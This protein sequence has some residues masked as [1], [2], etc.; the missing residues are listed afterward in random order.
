ME[1]GNAVRI[2]SYT[3]GRPVFAGSSEAGEGAMSRVLKKLERV[4]DQLVKKFGMFELF[5]IVQWEGDVSWDVLVVAPWINDG[6][7]N[8]MHDL[9][10]QQLMRALATPEL[11][12]ISQIAILGENDPT[13]QIANSTG[14]I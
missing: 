1:T 13:R 6:N 10:A 8:E 5:A 14:P 7:K 3:S 4:R 12:S 9:I 2:D 11:A